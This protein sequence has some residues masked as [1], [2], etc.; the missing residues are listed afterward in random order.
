M[1]SFIEIM[2]K[3]YA[4]KSFDENKK[5]SKEN[6]NK[7]LEFGRLSPSSFGLEHW[8]FLVIQNQELKN[9][10]MEASYKQQQIS[11]CSDLIII[12]AKKE[13]LKEENK[14]IENIYKSRIP[15]QIVKKLL[16]ITKQFIKQF[17]ND[18]ELIDWSKKQCYIAAANIMTG[19]KSIG[20]DSCPI[21]GFNQKEIE[22]ILEINNEKEEIAIIIPLGYGNDKQKDKTR[23]PFK[24]I[25]EFR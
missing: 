5:I 10:I 23:L 6:L 19:A 17:K 14:Y 22:K 1:E 25:I 21:E 18:R 2:N 13:E 4:A 8:K 20:I 7:I 11:K 3:R 15:E 24:K 16:T 9:K 12:L